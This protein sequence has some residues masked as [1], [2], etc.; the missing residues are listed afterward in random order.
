[1]RPYTLVRLSRKGA[2]I[3]EKEKRKTGKKKC[4]IVEHAILEVYDEF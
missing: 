4:K 3:L 2:E 1:M